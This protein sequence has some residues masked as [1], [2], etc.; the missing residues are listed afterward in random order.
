ML[1]SLVSQPPASLGG[2]LPVTLSKT[3]RHILQKLPQPRSPGSVLGAAG[4]SLGI[5]LRL[6]HGQN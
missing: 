6:Q 3:R 2:K 5:F 4:C 1:P